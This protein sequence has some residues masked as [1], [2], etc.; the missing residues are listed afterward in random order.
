MLEQRMYLMSLSED[1]PI[2]CCL[3]SSTTALIVLH[4]RGILLIYQL[5]FKG[6]K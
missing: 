4:A 5:V 1:L 3:V 6:R 2:L